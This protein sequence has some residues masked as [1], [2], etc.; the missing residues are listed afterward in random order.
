MRIVKIGKIWR[1]ETNGWVYGIDGVCPTLCCGCHSGVEPK[2]VVEESEKK[3]IMVALRGRGGI[4][5]EKD[6]WRLQLEIGDD[7]VSNT[8]TS[9]ENMH[10]ILEKNGTNV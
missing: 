1:S 4:V 7:I 5:G 3:K 9:V 2:I 8:I 6:T 10:L